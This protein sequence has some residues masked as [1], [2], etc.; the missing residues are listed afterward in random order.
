MPTLNLEGKEVKILDVG[1]GTGL[2]G[3]LVQN[4][5]SKVEDMHV[6]LQ[7]DGLDLTE[8]MID[9]AKSRDVYSELWNA[10]L[11]ENLP[12]GVD[13][14][15]YDLVVSSGAFRA[16]QLG[17]S[18]LEHLLQPLKPGGLACFT[19]DLKAWE[20]ESY[21]QALKKLVSDGECIIRQI[22]RADYLP[23]LRKDCSV[24]VL[25]KTKSQDNIVQE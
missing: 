25:A 17:P 21:Q 9:E 18:S 13:L 16:G 14:G 11:N 24:V 15:S 6:D 1:C 2:L 7:I 4:E 12:E 20:K 3:E 10:D 22:N 23:A 8:A 5:L 19:V